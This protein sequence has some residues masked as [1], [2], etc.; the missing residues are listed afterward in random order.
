MR[1]YLQEILCKVKPESAAKAK[2]LTDNTSEE[3][4]FTLLD[5]YGFLIVFFSVTLA[6]CVHIYY[7]FAC[8]AFGGCSF[9]RAWK[10]PYLP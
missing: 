1:W 9:Q 3:D 8:A 7:L 5:V 4:M 6:Q 2:A 10:N